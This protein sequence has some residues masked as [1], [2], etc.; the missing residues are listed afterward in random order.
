MKA[1]HKRILENIWN[2]HHERIMIL[3]TV[4]L[5]IGSALLMWQGVQKSIGSDG[6]KWFDEQIEADSK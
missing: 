6:G 2:E 1:N 3:G 4:I 5:G